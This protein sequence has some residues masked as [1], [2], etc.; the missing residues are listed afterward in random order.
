LKVTIGVEHG[1]PA[2]SGF[3]VVTSEYRVGELK[4]VIGVIGPTRMP[5]ERVIAMVDSTSAMV[6]EL[7]PAREPNVRNA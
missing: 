7:L 1:D 3:T 2:L 5:Y 4:G 6:S